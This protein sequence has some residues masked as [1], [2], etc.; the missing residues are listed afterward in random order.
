MGEE[1]TLMVFWQT[2]SE[3]ER[4]LNAVLAHRPRLT[5]ILGPDADYAFA[6][7]D[8]ILR[9][10]PSWSAPSDLARVP[11]GDCRDLKVLATAFEDACPDDD[12]TSEALGH[13]TDAAASGYWTGAD[14]DTETYRRTRKGWKMV[15]D[16]RGGG[17]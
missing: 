16:R 6:G 15:R 3:V 9:A 1:I 17:E 7:V 14:E 5:E 10:L 4:T 8:S 12:V 13:I 11:V 2:R